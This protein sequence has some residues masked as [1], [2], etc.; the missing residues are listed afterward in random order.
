MLKKLLLCSGLA[1]LSACAATAPP[2]PVDKPAATTFVPPPGCVGSTATR[3][4]T[5]PNE[6]AGFGSTYTQQDIER[7]G[8]PLVGGALRMLDPSLTVRGQ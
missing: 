5:S 1:L 8:Q 3:I 7:T 2:K 6:C 4:P